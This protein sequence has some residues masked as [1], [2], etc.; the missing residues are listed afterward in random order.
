MT[1]RY[2]CTEC[3]AGL[4][5]KDELAGTKGK[6]P[7]CKT[8]FVVPEPDS[9]PNRPAA[10]PKKS[11]EE[12]LA[13][14]GG[15]SA[16]LPPV[17]EPDELTEDPTASLF[18][19]FESPGVFV[20]DEPD[21]EDNAKADR[22]KKRD[23]K[24]KD[25]KKT[26]SSAA[27]TAGSAQALL[28]ATAEKKRMQAGMP[29]QGRSSDDDEES[30]AIGAIKFYGTKIGLPVLGIIAAC[31]FAYWFASDN[32]DLPPLGKV[33]GV[34]KLNG[35]PLAGASV[36]FERQFSRD[37]ERFNATAD[38][39]TNAQGEYE[40]LFSAKHQVYG[41]VIGENKVRIESDGTVFIP[42]RYN[43]AT[44]LTVDVKS[45]NDPADFSLTSDR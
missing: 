3:S 6:C 23:R 19:D 35:Q 40:L 41:A 18:D 21:P 38:A 9:A 8:K 37:E 26:H 39:V 31:C 13:E 44:E 17:D 34:V 24:S 30:Y 20:P 27:S 11:M 36:S 5:I 15:D 22:K 12:W 25:K 4:K 1:I 32:L 7:K 14:E 28:N 16:D 10:P 42:A 29:D 43:M 2:E 33:S 45:S